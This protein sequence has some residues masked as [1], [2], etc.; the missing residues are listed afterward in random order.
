MPKLF[1]TLPVDRDRVAELVQRH[2]D[3]DLGENLKASQNH[4]FAASDTAGK[5][6]AV[7]VTPD[8][9]NTQHGRIQDELSLVHYLSTRAGVPGVCGPVQGRVGDT[10]TDFAIRDGDLTLCV[11]HWAQGRP[12]QFQTY[13]WM[14][15]PAIVRAWGATLARI[16]RGT[17]VFARDHPQV[18]ARIRAWTE[19]H[20]GIMAPAA[21]ELHPDDA[22]VEA[23]GGPQYGILHGDLN[24]SNFFLA[25]GDEGLRLSVFDWDQVQ[26]GW[27][28]Y[29]LAQA[30]LVSVM[31]AE[32]GAVPTGECV[33]E[34]DPLAFEAWL[35][36]GYASV[37]GEGA[38]DRARL[39]RMIALRKD[40]YGR[41][42]ARAR[43]EGVP[44]G[45]R[46]F[47]DYCDRWANGS[48][49]RNVDCTF[50]DAPHPAASLQGWSVPR[51]A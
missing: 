23:A 22:A 27:Y 28:E 48:S 18:A 46:L 20:D 49:G 37:A 42:C 19:V 39:T 21:A 41:F 30:I 51:E 14:T 13:Q 17:S 1:E 29:D 8:P 40:F 15:D 43:Q 16:H 5:Q 4:T 38:I 33:P 12:A 10:A 36:E 7:R 34:A 11:F 35:V 3:L 31:L 2:W 45:M 32:A 47:V 44:E 9:R 6:Y 26:R 25:D 50:S 24:V